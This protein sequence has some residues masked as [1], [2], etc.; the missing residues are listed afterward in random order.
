[1]NILLISQCNKNALKESRRIIDQ[2]AERVGERSWQTHITE[3]GLE[4]LHKLLRKTA[5][6]NTAVACHWIRSKNHTELLWIVG[7]K[8]Q[9]NERGRVPTNRTNKNILRFNDECSQLSA[10]DIQITAVLAGLLHD[11]GKASNHFQNKLQKNKILAD[12]Y[13]HEWWS[14]RLL[15]IMIADCKSDEDCL[16]RLADW[17]SYRKK[18]PNWFKK[19]QAEPKQ[20]ERADR[21]DF[22]NF[23]P[24]LRVIA[25]LILSHHRMPIKYDKQNKELFQK[26]EKFTSIDEWFKNLIPTEYW[27]YNPKVEEMDYNIVS[28]PTTSEKWQKD[29]TRWANKAL[30]RIEEKRFF[31]INEQ[32]NLSQLLNDPLFLHLSR[33]CLIVGDH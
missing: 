5:R 19:L 20:N 25:W 26:Q 9:F 6:K 4:A 2:F 24:L 21:Y 27:I 15:Q 17:E 11:L 14:V 23:P 28:D 12:Q 1:M 18:N 16:K 33:L 30:K 32:G 13:R 8:S 7:D 31:A 29:L 22:S 10:A 3:K